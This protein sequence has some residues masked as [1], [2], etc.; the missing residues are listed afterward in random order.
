MSAE[1]RRPVMAFVVLAILAVS[2]VVTQRADA[3]VGRYL[4][5][6]SERS[7]AGPGH[8]HRPETAPQPPSSPPPCWS[9]ASGPPRPPRSPLRRPSNRPLRSP[10]RSGGG[11]RAESDTP[12]ARSTALRAAPGKARAAEVVEP[13]KPRATLSRAYVARPTEQARGARADRSARS[14]NK[15]RGS[16]EA[17]A[18]REVASAVL[19]ARGMSLPAAARSGRPAHPAHP[20]HADGKRSR[21][22]TRLARVGG[23]TTTPRPLD[24]PPTPSALGALVRPPL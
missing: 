16:S 3:G 14:R 1:H 9:T 15:S 7:P 19:A 23:V 24:L 17:M 11:T 13:A 12:R 22:L 21:T 18:P 5:P 2:V 10:R 8:G 20:P 4:P 6:T